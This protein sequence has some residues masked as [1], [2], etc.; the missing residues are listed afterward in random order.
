MSGIKFLTCGNILTKLNIGTLVHKHN[1]S[2]NVRSV[3]FVET[4]KIS[5]VYCTMT[6]KFLHCYI[7]QHL[8]VVLMGDDL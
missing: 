6:D 2:R 8:G 7:I 3:I 5:T 1:I 4:A